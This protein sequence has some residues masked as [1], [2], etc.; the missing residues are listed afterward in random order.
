M[1]TRVNDG[2]IRRSENDHI[3]K[4]P[5]CR[6]AQDTAH[7]PR[8]CSFPCIFDS[9]MEPARHFVKPAVI[10]WRV[11]H[12]GRPLR[13]KQ[14]VVGVVIETVP[15]HATS[16]ERR[17]AARGGINAAGFSGSTATRRVCA[18]VY[19]GWHSASLSAI[20]AE[21]IPA[22]VVVGKTRL[23]S[24]GS[25]CMSSASR[26]ECLT[27]PRLRST[28]YQVQFDRRQCCGRWLCRAA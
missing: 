2:R 24:S 9:S 28:G 19:P 11:Y 4:R 17:D 16:S 5:L 27:V 13:R 14:E 8:Y 22:V 21:E 1:P 3:T 23:V 18:P 7:I 26:P 15:D 20:F 12:N 25:H 10:S 6:V